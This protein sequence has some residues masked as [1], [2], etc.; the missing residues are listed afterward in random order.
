MD[1]AVDAFTNAVKMARNVYQ[2]SVINGK[3]GLTKLMMV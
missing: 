2:D 1:E 3:L